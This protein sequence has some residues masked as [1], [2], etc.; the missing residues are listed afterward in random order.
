MDQGSLPPP[1]PN[2]VLPAVNLAFE[3]TATSTPE[4]P[5]IIAFQIPG[6]DLTTFKQLRVLHYVDGTPVDVTATDPAPNFDTQTIYASVS[7]LSPFAL[8][9]VPGLPSLGGASPYTVFALNGPTSGGKQTASFSSG[10]D[11]GKVAIAAGATLQLQAP[12]TINGNLY[13]DFGGSVSGPG[14]VNGARFTNQDL[15]GARQDALDASSQAASLAPNVTYSNI[16]ALAGPNQGCNGATFAANS[17]V[18]GCGDEWAKLTFTFSGNPFQATTGGGGGN[19]VWSFFQDTDA[20]VAPEPL[21]WGL[22]G[23]GLLALATLRKR[24]VPG[25][26]R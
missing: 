8:A 21:T 15:S 20:A 17:T 5:F 11:N 4:P 7:S 13:V 24:R 26:F 25:A 2:F 19:A 14:K 23:A 22:M 9:A 12:F 1:P 10:T 18:T 16:L 3:I 6:V